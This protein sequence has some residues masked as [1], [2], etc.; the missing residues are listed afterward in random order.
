[1]P[2]PPPPDPSTDPT[3]PFVLQP[4]YEV[5]IHRVELV[6]WAVSDEAI[7]LFKVI[8]KAR[9]FVGQYLGEMDA[10]IAKASAVPPERPKISFSFGAEDMAADQGVAEVFYTA[11]DVAPPATRTAAPGATPPQGAGRA[12]ANSNQNSAPVGNQPQPG[13]PAIVAGP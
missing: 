6:K 4:W 5:P 10:K 3:Y 2:P 9:Y 8:P 11:A 1:M 13:S 7:E 12:M